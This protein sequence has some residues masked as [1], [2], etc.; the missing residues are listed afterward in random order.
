[1]PIKKCDFQ[2]EAILSDETGEF[3]VVGVLAEVSARGST[4]YF[5]S[6][7]R[8]WAILQRWFGLVVSHW[9]SNSWVSF[10]VDGL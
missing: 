7:G 2:A 1:M 5:R 3:P 9:P 4:G 10:S 8:V 6:S